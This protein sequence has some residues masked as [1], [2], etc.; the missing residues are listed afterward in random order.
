MNIF[1]ENLQFV[2]HHGVYEEEQREGRQFRVDLRVE[3]DSPRAVT[4]DDIRDTVDYRGLAEAVLEVGQGP[5][6]Q[7]I[8]RL[9]EKILE[10]VFER[11]P[12]VEGAEVTVRKYATGVPGAPECVGIE[13][14]RRRAEFD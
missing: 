1:V 11:F 12:S 4:T 7:L 10:G 3:V 5:S 13:L 6:C 14:S 8:E 2:G 9:G